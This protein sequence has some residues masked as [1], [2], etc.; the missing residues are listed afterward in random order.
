[1]IFGGFSAE[2]FKLNTVD[3]ILNWCSSVER[4]WNQFTLT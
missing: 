2:R 3:K 4:Q 1:M